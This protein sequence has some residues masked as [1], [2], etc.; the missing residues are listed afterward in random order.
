MVCFFRRTVAS[1]L[2][3]VTVVGPTA[4]PT[5]ECTPPLCD[6]GE[7][8]ACPDTCPGGC[9]TICATRTP[10]PCPRP[11]CRNDETFFCPDECP[12]GCG[13][14]CATRTPTPVPIPGCAGDCNDDG[15]VDISELLRG[16]RAALG[17]TDDQQCFVAFNRERTG[18]LSVDEL[19]A[20]VSNA[21]TGCGE[22]TADPRL[23]ACRNS[24][25]VD[26]ANS[27]C[28][29]VGDFRDTCSIGT[30][31]ECAWSARHEVTACVCGRDRCFDGARCVATDT[32]TPTPTLDPLTPTP[33]RTVDDSVLPCLQTGGTESIRLCCSGADNFPNTC[34]VG[35]CSCPPDVSHD[36]RVCECGVGRCYDP[37]RGGC[38]DFDSTT[39]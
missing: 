9:G 11:S 22:T 20:A 27:C 4:T 17:A 32:R 5:P 37:G 14:E 1:P 3:P 34:R 35:P 21:L 10:T 29:G 30:C 33:T 8:F 28:A 39:P 15:R 24:G 23:S 36:V 13:L 38:V 12:A 19:I 31:G 18:T 2:F 16:V 7:V 26:A 25:G 6:E